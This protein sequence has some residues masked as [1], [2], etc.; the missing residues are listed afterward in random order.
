MENNR[1]CECQPLRVALFPGSFNPFTIGHESIVRRALT[2]CDRLLIAVGYNRDKGV[3]AD[4]EKRVETIRRIFESE[5]RVDVAAYSGLTV[6][7]ARETGA[8]FMIRGVRSS[9]DFEYE[10]NL[11]DINRE[12]SGLETV[13][14]PAT[15]ALGFVSSSMVR[16]L[17]ANGYDTSRFIP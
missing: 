7:F 4:V 1:N 10:L 14:L 3:S 5:P 9:T 15:P 13:L 8:T 17:D 11:A 16:E 12:I 6:D 2:L